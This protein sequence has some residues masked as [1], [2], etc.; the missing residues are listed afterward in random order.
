MPAQTGLGFPQSTGSSFSTERTGSMASRTSA[1]APPP[2][3]P[4]VSPGSYVPTINNGMMN[5]DFTN[6]QMI[7]GD[8]YISPTDYCSTDFL[9]SFN[10]PF[11]TAQNDGRNGDF[12]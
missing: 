10:N 9:S 6:D 2:Y 7:Y 8:Q 5:H 1:I 12:L 3:T 11:S 4:H